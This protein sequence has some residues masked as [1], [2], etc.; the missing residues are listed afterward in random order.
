MIGVLIVGHGTFAAGLVETLGFVVGAQSQIAAI[1]IYPD[2]DMEQ[3]RRDMIQAIDAISDGDGVIILTDMFG[4]TPSNLA[5]S[6]MDKGK[7]EVIAGANLPMAIKLVSLREKDPLAGIESIVLRAQETG[8]KYINV[9]SQLLADAR[10][11]RNIGR[12][13]ATEDGAGSA[14]SSPTQGRKS[15][16]NGTKVRRT[17]SKIGKAIIDNRSQ[18]QI[19]TAALSFLINEKLESLRSQRPNSV[20]AKRDRDEQLADYESLR[21]QLAEFRAAVELF[22]GGSGKEGVAV[23]TARTFA[24]GVGSWWNRNHYRICE[25]AFEMGL[26]LSAVGICSIVGVGGPTSV[27]ISGALA[28]GK[29]VV[30]ALKSMAKLISKNPADQGTNSSLP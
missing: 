18:V 28:G 17:R 29:P 30:D 10:N 4:G 21:K 12:N 2:D 8:R 13:V 3:R 5:I 11:A 27:I 15:V 7:I 16:T 1:E 14:T 24:A 23:K 9:A 22:V 26:F 6:L 20:H 19:T 25:R